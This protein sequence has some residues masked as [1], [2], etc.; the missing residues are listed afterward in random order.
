MYKIYNGDCL[1]IMDF[2][3]K[4]GVKVDCILTDP[5]YGTT[6]CK[7]D[8]VIP[9]DKMWERLNKLI[10]PNGAIV[11]FSDNPF[12]SKLINSNIRNYKYDWIWEKEQGK[13]FQ[14]CK[15]MPLKKTEY[16]NVFINFSQLIIL[17][18]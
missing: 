12:T 15:R 10:K 11:L 17:K 5:P 18:I 2:L 13:N 8:S 7:W 3:I 16:I 1:E 6:A 14:H 4:E 9:F